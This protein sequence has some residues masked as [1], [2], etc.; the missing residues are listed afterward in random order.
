MANRILS[1]GDH[2]RAERIAK[3]LDSAVP[4]SIIRSTR[5]FITFTG[6]YKGVPVSIIGTGMGVPMMDFVVRETRAITAGP[7]AILRYG[8]CGGLRDCVPGTIAVAREARLVLRN[9]D[10]VHEVS[11]E[12][13]DT[14]EGARKAYLLS[15]PVKADAG[16]ADLVSEAR[17][18]GQ[19]AGKTGGE[20]RR[21]HA[22]MDLRKW[23]SLTT[24]D[25]SACSPLLPCPSCRMM[26]RS[27]THH[28]LPSLPFYAMLCTL[29]SLSLQYAKNL[30]AAMAGL[31]SRKS[32]LT[33]GPY[34]VRGGCNVTAESFYSSQG[35]TNSCFRDCNAGLLERIEADVPNAINLEMETFQLL[36]LGA[37]S[38]PGKTIAA[39]G[40]AMV[41]ANR[42]TQKVL[43]AEELVALEVEGGRAC[44]ETLS[45]FPLAL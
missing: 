40:A 43:T 2:G 21:L 4:V 28:P 13:K 3:L 12:L 11:E 6:A 41:M 29:L 45:Q 23:C 18:G 5:G 32:E 33:P 8:T 16:L 1:V 37:S 31:E 22:C 44:L 14:V 34:P 35:R 26:L 20:R 36:E 15:K 38:L 24:C 19:L 42:H 25:S 39:A 10:T 9:P 17:G 7:M 30:E 27:L